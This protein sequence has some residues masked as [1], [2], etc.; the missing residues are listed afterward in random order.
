MQAKSCACS[1]EHLVCVLQS[2]AGAIGEML[3]LK[4]Q[5]E[6]MKRREGKTK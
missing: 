3:H 1:F 6:E 5:K 2:T 4:G